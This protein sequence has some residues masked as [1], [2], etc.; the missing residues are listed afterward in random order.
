VTTD[1]NSQKIFSSSSSSSITAL[2]L[3]GVV[4]E[5]SPL[6]AGS[7]AAGSAEVP[8]QGCRTKKCHEGLMF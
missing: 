5:L 6:R 3:L 2:S 4:V 1:I 7:R 8:L